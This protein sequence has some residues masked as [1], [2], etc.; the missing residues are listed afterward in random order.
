MVD[1]IIP[2]SDSV[3][4]I[5]RLF[6]F[7]TNPSIRLSYNQMVDIAVLFILIVNMICGQ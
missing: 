2:K 5:S 4:F 7:F 1:N 6:W 3:F